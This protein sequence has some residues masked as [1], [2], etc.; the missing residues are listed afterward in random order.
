MQVD[1]GPE[2]ESFRSEMRA[3]IEENAPA[4]LAEL[5]DWNT[6]ATGGAPRRALEDAQGQ[7]LYREWEERLLGA[8]LV[9]PQWPDGV[10]GRGLSAAELA[11]LNEEFHR[12][13]VP[14]VDRGMG[15]SLVGPSVIVHG[16]DEQRARFLPRIIAGEDRYCQ[17]FSEPDHGSDLGGVETRGLVD[18]DEVVISG[19]KVWTSGAM[20]A[21]M[22][23]VL[24]RTDPDVPKHRGLSYILVPMADNHIE[25]API[26]QM[27]GTAEFCQEFLTGARAPLFNV[28]GGLNNGWRVA[29]T[30]LGNER[31]GRATIQHLTYEKEFWDLVDTVRKHGQEGDALTRQRL[32]W[33]FTH[34]ELMRYSG[35]RLLAALASQKEPGPEASV[36]KLFWSEYHKRFGEFAVD[37][38]GPEAMLRPEGEGYPTSRW[39]AV[40]L[41]SRAGTIFSGTSEIQKKIIGERALGLPKEPGAG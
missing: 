16:T 13:G 3:W 11:V 38:L 8:R 6:P 23:F 27:A 2:L 15:E 35:L 32:A 9:C 7:A 26:R 5:A 41:W 28:I 30:T 25:I 21:N 31:G 1:L 14:R 20:R 22:I 10:G 19:Q 4:G 39:Q 37:I 24:C 34:V 33:A 17:G 12:A 18:G 29:M 40:F 36:S